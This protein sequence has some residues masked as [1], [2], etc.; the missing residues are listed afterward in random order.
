M[1]KQHHSPPRKITPSI[2]YEQPPSADVF[3]QFLSNIDGNL[4]EIGITDECLHW[5]GTY[6]KRGI[7]S[8]NSPQFYCKGRR[9][10]AKHLAL[11]WL[12]N[13]AVEKRSRVTTRCNH[14]SCVNPRHLKVEEKYTKKR[15][16]H[17]S[18]QHQLTFRKRASPV[19]IAETTSIT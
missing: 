11:T 10:R 16:E 8:R 14:D 2:Y 19:F 13:D 12:A 15:R 17:I 4:S 7:K 1:P 9:Y 18:D 6:T 3:V 5:G